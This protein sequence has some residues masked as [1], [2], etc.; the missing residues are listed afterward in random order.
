[1][2]SPKDP[3]LGPRHFTRPTTFRPGTPVGREVDG[4]AHTVGSNG[5][6]ERLAYAMMEN[7]DEW[8]LAQTYHVIDTKTGHDMGLHWRVQ[9]ACHTLRRFTFVGVNKEGMVSVYKP[10]KNM[11]GPGIFDTHGIEAKLVITHADDV[12]VWVRWTDRLHNVA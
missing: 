10:I 4:V 5:E 6:L 11:Y 2:E 7:P 9:T 8:I 12:E 3:G 1:M